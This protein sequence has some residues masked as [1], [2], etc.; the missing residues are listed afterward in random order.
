[1]NRST[2]DQYA[3]LF[4]SGAAIEFKINRGE[5]RHALVIDVAPFPRRVTESPPP[6]S[7]VWL[8]K[9]TSRVFASSSLALSSSCA[10]LSSRYVEAAL[11]QSGSSRARVSRSVSGGCPFFHNASDKRIPSLVDPRPGA[12]IRC[13]FEQNAVCAVEHKYVGNRGFRH[14]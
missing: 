12:C 13:D 14:H 6:C 8:A 11:S 7:L 10:D 4:M 2:V 1:L 5:D 3:Y 9:P